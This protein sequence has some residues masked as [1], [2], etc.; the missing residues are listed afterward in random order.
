MNP[1]QLD[2]LF[3]ELEQVSG[4]EPESRSLTPDEESKPHNMRTLGLGLVLVA[5]IV[6]NM[7]GQLRLKSE[8]GQG[9]RFAVQL[10]FHLPDESPGS[11]GEGIRCASH[12]S[13]PAL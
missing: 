6:R 8:E 7:D 3:R 5:R 11:S 9:S 1:Q 10:P 13:R 12:L 2:A 4:E